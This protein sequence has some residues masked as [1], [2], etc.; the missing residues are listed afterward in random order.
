MKKLFTTLVFASLGFC[1]F[2]Q[3]GGKIS[4]VIQDGGNQKI[5]DAAAISLLKAKDS[6]LVKISVTDKD[7]NFL[8]ENVKDGNYIVSASSIG[9]TKVYS[10]PLI[11]DAGNTW[12]LSSSPFPNSRF[13]IE[14]FYNQ[15]A[16]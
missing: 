6:S 4:G 7:G 15:N 2:A 16:K 13:N 10:Q 9:H 14:N 11:I 12:M 3:N 1:S 8:F 5:I